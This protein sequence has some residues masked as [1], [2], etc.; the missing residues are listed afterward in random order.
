MP[1]G[2]VYYSS[3]FSLSSALDGV[4]C[5]HHALAALPPGNIHCIEAWVGPIA[6]ENLASAVIRSPDSPDHSM[7]LYG[8]YS[9]CSPLVHGLIF[10]I[11]EQRV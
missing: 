6:P 8:M 3:T 11:K 4:G 9:Y 10:R 2:G 1:K 5:Q 7:P